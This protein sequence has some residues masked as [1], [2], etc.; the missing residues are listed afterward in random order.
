MQNGCH[1]ILNI[2]AQKP[3]LFETK[4]EETEAE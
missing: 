1:F 2:K 4:N 3:I